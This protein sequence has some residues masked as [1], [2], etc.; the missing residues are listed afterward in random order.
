MRS[1]CFLYVLVLVIIAIVYTNCLTLSQQSSAVTDS[2]GTS[3]TSI[4]QHNKL[5]NIHA[6]A[7][8]AL[9]KAHIT[10]DAT[11][12]QYKVVI[13]ADGGVYVSILC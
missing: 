4:D 2:R 5:L 13:R 11:F 10:F 7:A 8:S 6:S 9:S 1:T 3:K 12:S